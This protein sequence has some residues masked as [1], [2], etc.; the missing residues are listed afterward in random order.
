MDYE[1]LLAIWERE[2][3]PDGE[4]YVPLVPVAPQ[5]ESLLFVGLNPS[6]VPAAIQRL[7]PDRGDPEAY[8]SWANRHGFDPT[9]DRQLQEDAKGKGRY[10]YFER[11]RR[12]A[13]I[14]DVPWDHTDLFFWRETSQRSFSGRV[15]AHNSPGTLTPFGSEQLSISLRMIEQSHP[16]CIVV[17]NAL[18]SKI[19]LAARNPPFVPTRGCY[20]DHLGGSAVP[21]FPS[22]ML[23]GQR[24]L[25]LHSLLRLVWHVGR[26]LG[27]TVGDVSQALR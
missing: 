18:A 25:D 5:P 21:V 12:I 7:L 9:V 15:L 24:A 19:Y 4:G 16:R 20:E 10:E 13:E 8:F 11:F 27:V 1:Q 6:F 17:A 3:G 26:E 2:L 22:S 23:T 14:L